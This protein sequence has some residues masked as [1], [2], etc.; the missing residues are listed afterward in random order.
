ME[1]KIQEAKIKEKQK[2]ERKKNSESTSCRLE[3]ILDLKELSETTARISKKYERT[4][5]F[6]PGNT[7]QAHEQVIPNKYGRC[8][9]LD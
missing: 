3:L 1:K 5:A 9:S 8:N 4:C 7:L 6:K 2:D